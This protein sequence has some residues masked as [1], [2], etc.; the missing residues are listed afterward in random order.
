[1]RGLF[2]LAAGLVIIQPLRADIIYMKNGDVFTGTITHLDSA[3]IEVELS[4]GRRQSLQTSAVFRATDDEGRPLFRGLLPGG[5]LEQ[6]ISTSQT[7]GRILE[8]NSFDLN[9]KAYRKVVRFPFWPFLGGTAVLGYVGIT[10]L[11][12][13]AETYEDSQRLEE[14]GLPFNTTRDRSLKQKTWGQIATA[15]AAACFIVAL[16]P[17]FEKV[18]LHSALRVKPTPNGV[19]LTLNW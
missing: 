6:S 15:G 3:Y 18:P 13:S 8:E 4:D 7:P 16:T 10:Q 11:N 2:I 14:S 5:G 12:K 9:Q 19:A 1:M 17:Q